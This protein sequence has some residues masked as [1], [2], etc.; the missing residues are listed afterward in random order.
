MTNPDM[1]YAQVISTKS[2]EAI[3]VAM[4]LAALKKWEDENDFIN[5]MVAE[6]DMLWHHK[7]EIQLNQY[8]ALEKLY[9]RLC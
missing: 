8:N 2:E 5:E 3:K 7:G 9:R 1:G 4:M 6:I